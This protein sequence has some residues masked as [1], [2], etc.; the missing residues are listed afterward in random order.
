[1]SDQ[2]EILTKTVHSRSH[3]SKAMWFLTH[4]ADR[5]PDTWESSG[6]E[7]QEWR[8]AVHRLGVRD[9]SRKRSTVR[10]GTGL[11]HRQPCPFPVLETAR[12]PEDEGHQQTD[13]RVPSSP[14]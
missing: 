13:L 6:V 3:P 14:S 7:P 12:E 11:L 10:G 5:F 9:I 1:M 4:L 8:D 2:W